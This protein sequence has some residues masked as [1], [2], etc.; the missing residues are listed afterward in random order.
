MN[1]VSLE[2]RF[3][4]RIVFQVCQFRWNQWNLDKCDK[5]NVAP[6][7]AEYVLNHPSRG[8]PRKIGDEKKL[9]IGQTP[10]G[11]FLQVIYVIDPDGTLFVIH[12]RPLTEAE[13][14]AVRRGRRR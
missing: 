10:D 7:E 13:K 11:A 3:L 2:C 5:H 6:S 1:S 14:H 12:A 8:Y 4:R 9:A